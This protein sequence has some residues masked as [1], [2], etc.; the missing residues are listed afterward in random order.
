M[1]IYLGAIESSVC[2][3]IYFN[4]DVILII[5]ILHLF[6]IKK[7]KIFFVILTVRKEINLNEITVILGYKNMV[8]S[9]VIT[10]LFSWKVLFMADLFFQILLTSFLKT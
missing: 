5:S 8:D 2:F 6:Y 4:I 10:F 1:I 3:F 9:L 7:E